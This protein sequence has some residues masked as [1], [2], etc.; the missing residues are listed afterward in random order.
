[1]VHPE[2]QAAR[3]RAMQVAIESCSEY[4]SEFR[5]VKPDGAMR[6]IV[7]RGIAVADGDGK[8]VRV[9]GV[10][11]DIT[12][13]KQ[14]EEALRSS[15]ARIASAIE[16]AGM[17]FYENTANGR[18]LFVDARLRNMLGL[19]AEQEVDIRE[20]WLAGIHPEDRPEIA[21]ASQRILAG[22]VDRIS[23]SYRYVHPSGQ[24]HWFQHLSRILE[25]DDAGR[26]SR[27]IGVILDITERRNAEEEV[28][29]LSH[30]VEHSPV[31]VVITDLRGSIVYVNRKFCE[32][33]GYSVGE[34]IGNNP[35]ILKSG[36]T[37]PELYRELWAC[38]AGGGT[39]RGEFHNRKKNGEFY[40]E[41][42]VISPLLDGAGKV[43][44]YIGLKED[45]T[46][47]KIAEMETAELRN[48]LTHVTR[49]AAVGELAASL[50]HELN[51]PLAAIIAN[52]DAAEILAG[53]PEPDLTEIQSILD[54]IRRDGMRA[55]ETIHRMRA[56]LQ[57]RENE[58]QPVDVEDLV[59]ES[60]KFVSMDAAVRKI[61]LEFRCEPDMRMGLGDRIQLQQVLLNLIVNGMDAMSDMP[62]GA[63]RL[64]VNARQVST[65]L[66]EI[67]VTDRGH[68]ILPDQ[69]AQVF[70]PF[71][72]TKRS[73][74]GMGL[75]ISR[76]IVE[77]HGGRLGLENNPSGGATARFTIPIAVKEARR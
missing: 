10:A 74:L 46:E 3:S 54:D 63:R 33:S 41:S 14:R 25:R 11:M 38:I 52:T 72:T 26:M 69:L 43:T 61:T 48:E 67:S 58:V 62:E 28:R 30:A 60:V 1:V 77:A 49:V 9:A 6:W 36:E 2:D 53:R 22:D 59:R 18:V 35:R 16:I 39:W 57:R 71:F 66:I 17:G 44:H 76:T 50:A 15:E 4:A 47:R 40:W 32:V 55:G 34:S 29:R 45:I 68:G 12:E 19:P 20:F 23:A 5:I 7:S 73:G 27:G 56:F 64:T 31:S 42:S 51:Q 24:Q 75:A 37:G 8:A 70:E 65:G 13:S 21:A